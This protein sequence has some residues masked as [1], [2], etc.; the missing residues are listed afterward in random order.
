MLF[1]GGDESAINTVVG[2]MM[3]WPV[4]VIILL[5]ALMLI[6]WYYRI[7]TFLLALVSLL[8]LLFSVKRRAKLYKQKI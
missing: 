5:V 4:V 2:V 1:E 6:C 7:D 8:D 3:L